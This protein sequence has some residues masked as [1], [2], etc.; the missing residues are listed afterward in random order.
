MTNEIRP[1][2]MMVDASTNVFSKTLG[3]KIEVSLSPIENLMI[4][5]GVDANYISRNGNR[6]RKIKIMNGTVLPQPIIKNDKV[7]Q[8]T[9]LDDIGVF[10]ELKYQLK[11]K[12]TLTFGLRADFIS[13]GIADPAIQI[14]DLYGTIKDKTETNFSGNIAIKKR[15]KNAQIQLAY[16]RG[17]RTASMVERYINHFSIG[18]DP[19]EYIG[20]PNLKPEINN[21]IELSYIKKFDKIR[22]ETSVFYSIIEDYIT[23]FVNE[24]IPR[25]FMP[26][27]E[28][29]FTKQFINVDK[30][31]QS[32][33]ELNFDYKATNNLTFSSNI[34]YTY[35]QNK[36]F[37]EPLPQIQPLT[38]NINSTFAKNKYWLKLNAHFVAKQDRISTTFREVESNDYATF[39][40]S[41]GY[42][43]N[44]KLSFGISV[45]NIFDKTYYS[46]LNFSFNNSNLNSGKIFETGRNFTVY[47]KYKF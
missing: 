44:K 36:D 21:Q 35:A 22:V 47:T 27:L 45:L 33:F 37:N 8:D 15:F 16:G 34:A 25:L 11:N 9:N 20:N 2:F 17:A 19:Y 46:H 29:R 40:F 23:A 4:F 10:S 24:D 7:W 39:D 18:V 43:P 30:A 13:T 12:T 3:G 38:A 1:N 28:P 5:T 32:G 31:T 41:V 26:M 42:Q 6:I 14:T